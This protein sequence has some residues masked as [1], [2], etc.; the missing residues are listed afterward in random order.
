V[1][2]TATKGIRVTATKSLLTRIEGTKTVN[3]N[4][5]LEPFNTLVTV[6]KMK[7]TNG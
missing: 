1:M 6:K 4:E 2:A 3:G 5:L 7:V